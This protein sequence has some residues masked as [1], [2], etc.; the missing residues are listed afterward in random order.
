VGGGGSLLRRSVASR[1]SARVKAVIVA[2]ERAAPSGWPNLSKLAFFSG[3]DSSSK[4]PAT[5]AKWLPFKSE[6]AQDN[7]KAQHGESGVDTR[8]SDW[9]GGFSPPPPLSL[10]VPSQPHLSEAPTGVVEVLA[11]QALLLVRLYRR[12]HRLVV[13]L[14]GVVARHPRLAL[15]V[16]HAATR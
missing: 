1:T 11:V 3:S 10:G 9:F 15:G 5:S 13:H 4:A 12:R 14:L 7:K 8:K 16:F 6:T 2:S